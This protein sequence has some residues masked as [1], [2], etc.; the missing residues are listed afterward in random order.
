VDLAPMAPDDRTAEQQH[1]CALAA[2]YLNPGS[3]DWSAKKFPQDSDNDGRPDRWTVDIPAES[4]RWI[5]LDTNGDGEIDVAHADVGLDGTVD[6]AA[7]LGKAGWEETNLVESWLEMGF[8]LPWARSSYEKH[9]VDIVVN[10]TVVGKLR[11][12]VP[13]G[14]YAFRIPPPAL[15]FTGEGTPARNEVRIESKHLRGGHYV[16]S[17]DFRMK[18]KLTG[19]RVYAAAASLEEAKKRVLATPGLTLSAPDL[20]VS[21]QEMSVRFDGEPKGGAPMVVTVPLRNVGAAPVRLVDV[22]LRF[23]AGGDDIEL[24]RVALPEVPV[25]GTTLVEIPAQ[26][27]AGQVTLKVVVDPDGKTGDSERS[28][29]ECRAALSTAGDKAKPTLEVQAPAEGARLENPVVALAG[30]AGDDSGIARVEVRVDR[31]LWARLG[32]GE[33]GF[34]GKALLQPGRH[35]LTYRAI[36]TS[37]NVAERTVQV[38]VTAPAPAVE[39]VSPK[40]GAKIDDRKPAVVLK[41]SEGTV[42]AAVRA[43]GGPWQRAAVRAGAAEILLPLAFGGARLEAMAVDGRGMRAIA[44][45]QVECT[46]QPAADEATGR[47]EGGR[48]QAGGG[49][50][51]ATIDI[52]GLGA[53]DPFGEE[54]PVV[55]DPDVGP[56]PQV[57]AGP[58]EGRPAGETPR[59]GGTTTPDGTRRPG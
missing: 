42:A 16:V 10:D 11:D 33:A 1:L 36:D 57:P 24:A 55:A 27:P 37:G 38:T 25:T 29:N 39:I 30:K 6:F 2:A 59:P 28:N 43:N 46:R 7:I 32:R 47:D 58:G 8:K 22:V 34:S 4:T 40:A 13:E 54:N 31:G 21:S 9:D 18:M 19:T 41:C 44:Q 17:S 45:R 23:S 3:V 49:A 53:S 51:P 50:G 52:P 15:S 56:A 14:N 5:G 26:A 35:A 20:S 48:D 12:T